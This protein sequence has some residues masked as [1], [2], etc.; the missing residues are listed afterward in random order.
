MLYYIVSSVYELCNV[1]Y[2][3][4]YV[5]TGNYLRNRRIYMNSAVIIFIVHQQWARL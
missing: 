3:R 1:Y 2:K 4:Y 5:S